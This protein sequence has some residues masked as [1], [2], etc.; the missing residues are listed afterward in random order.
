MSGRGRGRGR[1]KGGR[2]KGKG[3]GSSHV[4]ATSAKTKGLCAAL[5]NHVFEYGQKESADQVRTTW[6]KI[7]QYS[8]TIYGHDIS[9]EL[10]N[11]KTLVIQE[12]EYSQDT[13]TEHADA[14]QRRDT[15]H[16]RITR[17]RTAKKIALEALSDAGDA[18]ATIALAELQNEMDEAEYKVS[19]P[20]PMILQGDEKT[21]H[22]NEWRTYRERVTR[23]EKQRGQ[24][25]SL[26]RGQCQQVLL[27][28]MKHDADWI[29]CSESYDPLTLMRLIERTVNAQTDDQ[30]PYGTVYEQEVAFYSFQQGQS[31]NDHW[32]EKFNTRVDVGDAIGIT[33]Q[34]KALLKFET[35]AAHPGIEFAKLTEA[36]QA[37]IREK[38]EEQYLSYVF[39]RQSG[40]QHNKCKVDLNNDYTE[41][42]DLFPKNRQAA[43]HLLNKYSKFYVSKPTESQ[44]SSYAQQGGGG[45]SPKQKKPYDK[46]HWKDKNCFNCGKLGHPS[47]QCPDKK[48]AAQ[49]AAAKKAA[50]QKAAKKKAK[51]KSDDEDDDKS[52]KSSKSAKASIKKKMKQTKRNYATLQTKLEDLEEEDSDMTD[53]DDSN[54]SFFQ[55]L[56][57]V[58]ISAKEEKEFQLAMKA[59]KKADG[60]A[61]IYN[62][63]HKS[64][65]LDMF[66]EQ[67]LDNQST[68]DLYGNEDFVT[69]IRDVPPMYVAGTGGVLK[70]T[71]KATVKGYNREVWFSKKSLTNVLCWK[72]VRE[73]YPETH[74]DV[75]TGTFVVPRG[76]EGNPPPSI[77]DASMWIA[78]TGRNRNAS[79]QYSIREYET[80]QQ[81]TNQGRQGSKAPVQDAWLS[82]R[83]GF[84]MD[85]AQQPDSWLQSNHR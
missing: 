27:D 78:S 52:S 42:E 36:Q 29:T 46:E 20:L 10:Q 64:K 33:R 34:H 22:D 31:T 85:P 55:M 53:S 77:P 4:P 30:Y 66:K 14:T 16:A 40:T 56:H 73:E 74:F 18:D 44:G 35:E 50:A 13:L 8:G 47:T 67:I 51:K 19:I 81:A 75:E 62:Q 49:T 59:G 80:V 45:Q 15:H 60:L 39:F 84:Q 37:K 41:G 21:K 79:G 43:L 28:R 25:F 1:G 2:G 6:D 17:A 82:F 7:V 12:P 38:A 23:L 57:C 11:K 70:V 32:Y 58:P 3:R 68:L 83:E 61:A 26:I 65:E 24:A 5:G 69:D 9:N 63:K 72:N 48:P 54:F 76:H 71:Q